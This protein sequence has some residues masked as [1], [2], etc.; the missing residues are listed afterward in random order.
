MN[1]DEARKSIHRQLAEHLYQAGLYQKLFHLLQKRDWY[2][3]KHSNDWARASYVDDIQHGM[4]SLNRERNIRF[5]FGCLHSASFV[6]EQAS[7]K[8]SFQ[9]SYQC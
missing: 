8:L 9:P 1:L 2:L 4:E 5:T 3:M 6:N 7:T